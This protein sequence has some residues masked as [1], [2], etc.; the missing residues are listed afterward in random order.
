M[1]CAQNRFE[2]PFVSSHH[3][4]LEQW[5]ASVAY[6]LTFWKDQAQLIPWISQFTKVWQP[7]QGE[8]D[9][10]VGKWFVDGKINI[11]SVCVDRWATSHPDTVAFTW[12]GEEDSEENP[13]RTH[14][15]YAELSRLV[16][17]AANMLLHHQVRRGDRVG[18]W[19]PMVPEAII[20]LFACAKIGAIPTVVFSGF[21][22]KNTE[23]RLLNAECKVL[24]TAHGGKR[25][26]KVFSLR[27]S[28]S[29]NFV[30]NSHLRAIICVD[31]V[32]ATHTTTNKDCIWHEEITSM[33]SECEPAV[34]DSED[35]LFLLYTSGTT[36]KPKGI[37]HSTGGYMVYATST[38]RSIWGIQGLHQPSKRET[39]FCTADIGWITGHSYVVY[40]PFALGTHVIM[41]EGA[42]NYPHAGRLF[43]IIDRFQISHLYTSPTLIRQLAA[44][45]DTFV[46]QYN[47][48]SLRALGSVGE[49]INSE[50]WHW[51][52]EKLG[53][54]SCPIVD[55]YWQTETGGYLFSPCAGIT[56][57][58]PGSCCIPCL[59]IQP[60]ILSDNGHDV[61]QGTK[62]YLCIKHPWPGMMRT[63]FK[64]H[65]RFLATYLNKVP[66]TY[67]TG[68][69]AYHDEDGYVWIAGRADDV[70]K[71]SGHRF[72]SAEL[73]ENIAHFPHVVESAVVPLPD[74]ITG[75]SIA[76]FVVSKIP[77]DIDGVKE[78]IRKTYGPIAIPKTVIQVPDLPKTCSG[79]VMRRML[80][81]IFLNHEVGD[82]STLVNP[83]IIQTLSLQF[84][85]ER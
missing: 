12:I 64:D 37:V 41:Y 23:E 76:A 25:R 19:L 66:G 31:T 71:V 13:Q 81:N 36:G 17:Q 48:S 30:Q 60:A 2:H 38:M 68:D 4:Y 75:N 7:P 79:K 46:S 69:E 3:E 83:D 9:A 21:S 42:F 80:K 16:N 27:D 73:E 29:E 82:T 8:Q 43:D 55:T 70:I 1:D 34:M 33:S 85:Q 61:T 63:I 22:A 67:A 39:W 11:A 10:F 45:G 57:E 52:H 84:Q 56:K 20:A 14:Y 49:P 26:G 28:L 78:H 72:G 65:A 6:P 24:I 40:A 54:S 32:P 15:T 59:G 44:D 58:K 35:P 62:G 18:I 74:P 51:Y 77:L 47:L 5:K 50:A 53:K